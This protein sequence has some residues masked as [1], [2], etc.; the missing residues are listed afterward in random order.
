MLTSGNVTI[1][2]SAGTYSSW[3]AFWD[4]LGNLT[5]NIT[6][7]VDASAFTEAVGPATVAE[8]LN[9]YTLHVLP[10]AFPTTTDASTGARFTC[11]LAGGALRLQTEGAG[12]VTIEGMVFIEGT[13]NPFGIFDVC[14]VSTEITS[15]YR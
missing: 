7:T 4:D 3:A 1:K 5:G 11:N 10:A 13:N 8:S 14:A 9:G 2:L 15:T 12:A 6:C